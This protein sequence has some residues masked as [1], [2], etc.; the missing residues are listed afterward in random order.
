MYFEKKIQ[1]CSRLCEF[2]IFCIHYTILADPRVDSLS[3]P[4]VITI[5]ASVNCLS[6]PTFQNLAKQSS[7]KNSDRYWRECG[8]GRVDHR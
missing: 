5:F 7:S 3:R 6:I 1:A 2:M 4:V 8:S